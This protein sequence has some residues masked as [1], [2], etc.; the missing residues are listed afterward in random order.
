MK[1]LD[2]RASEILRALLA[3]KTSKIDYTDEAYM[4]V[5]NPV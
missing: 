5:E 2:K 3:L 1:T 4:P